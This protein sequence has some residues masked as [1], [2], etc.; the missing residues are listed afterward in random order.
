MSR[1]V[2]HCAGLVPISSLINCI[3]MTGRVRLLSQVRKVVRCLAF[4]IKLGITSQLY[5]QS[6][7]RF[8]ELPPPLR[9]TLFY[10]LVCVDSTTHKLKEK[11]QGRPVDEITLSSEMFHNCT[12]STKLEGDQYLECQLHTFQAKCK[13][14]HFTLVLNINETSCNNL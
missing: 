1:K 9:V 8:R 12:I 6:L 2:T 7:R 13:V 11:Q 3:G 14:K 10:P 4:S 5:V